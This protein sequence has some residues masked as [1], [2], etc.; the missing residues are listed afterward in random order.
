MANRKPLVIVDG[1]VRQM[2]AADILDVKLNEV[3][4]V[5]ADNGEIAAIVICTPVYVSAADEVKEA[6][7]DAIS[8][9]EVIGLVV[10]DSVDPGALARILTDGRFTATTDQWDAVTGDV[11]GLTAGVVY[12]L[13]PATAG[14]LTATAPSADTKVVARVGKA[15][16]ATVLDISID[17]PILL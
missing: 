17:R 5:S 7:A 15:L 3:D 12:Y 4:F 14:I 11:G 6:Q 13:D 10:D 8:T 16:S 2:A 1:V 9:S